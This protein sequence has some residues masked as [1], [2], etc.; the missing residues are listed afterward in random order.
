MADSAEIDNGR[1]G[2]RPMG[3]IAVVTDSACDLARSF[4]DERNVRIVPLTIRFGADELVDGVDLST[5]EFWDRVISGPD[6]P[7]TAAPAPGSFQEAFEDAAASGAQGVVCV[8]LSSKLSAT[9]Q[10]AHAG[11]EAMAADIPVRVIDSLSAT[12]GQGLLVL[13][14]ADL[15]RDGHGLDEIASEV[16]DL[17]A[18]TRV[19]G[20]VGG[21][22]HLK[23]GGRIGGAA[24]LVGSLLSIKPVIEIRDGVVQVESKQRTRPRALTYLAGKALEAGPLERLAVATGACDDLSV[25]MDQLAPVHAEAETVVTE[26]GPVVGSHAGPGTV[27]VCFQLAR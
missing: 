15:A 26:L 6:L 18:R 9:C 17:R 5:K 24:H 20:V 27:G 3:G 14:A 12:V 1:E 11:A 22:D 4:A 2:A 25:L 13:A 23:K 7:E 10:A 8:T 16:E 21:L 19:Y